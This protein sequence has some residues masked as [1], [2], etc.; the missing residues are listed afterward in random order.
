MEPLTPYNEA[1]H[2]DHSP[3]LGEL[4]GALAKAQAEMGAA[5]KGSD[6]PFFKSSYADLASIIEAAR[7]LSTHGLAVTQFPCGGELVT[8]LIHSSGQWLKSRY[9][10]KP[11]KDDPQGR[12]SALTYARRYAY[13]AIA[14]LASADD[15]GEGAMDRPVQNAVQKPKPKAKAKPVTVTQIDSPPDAP[16]GSWQDFSLGFGK[17]KGKTLGD[18]A[19]TSD[20]SYITWLCKQDNSNNPELSVALGLAERELGTAQ[21]DFE[22]SKAKVDSEELTLEEDELPF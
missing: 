9:T 1:M 14:G 21:V 6:N 22:P 13:Q 20:A 7:P 12:G 17:H 3:D 10:I 15:D 4:A 5:L 19:G 11:V 18:L 16:S 8:M 2:P